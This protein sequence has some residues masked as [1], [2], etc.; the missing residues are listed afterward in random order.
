[1]AQHTAIITGAGG[2][3]GGHVIKAFDDAGWKLALVAFNDAESGRL[4]E[5]YGKHSVVQANLVSDDAAQRAI[6][7][8]V[9][10]LG[11]LDALLNIAGGFDM[12]SAT[13]TSPVQ[14]EAQ[15]DI[16]FR[17]AFNATRAA[18]PAML[19]QGY[20]FVL[21]IGAAAAMD[22]GASVGAYAAAKGALT[23]W[24]KSVQ[25]EL[26]PKGISTAVMHPM[27]AVDTPANRKAMA[28][29]DPAT[30]IDADELAA[31]ALHLATRGNRGRINELKV[32]PPTT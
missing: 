16:N 27:G 5:E 20:G 6:R 3:I 2:A 13:D 30:W 1:M 29:A 10:H 22:G 24:M 7:E 15:L 19:R 21:A 31:S 11:R 23:A 28:D 4:R 25:A 12:S 17:T 9:S 18:L 26:A 8:A 14:L 32:Y